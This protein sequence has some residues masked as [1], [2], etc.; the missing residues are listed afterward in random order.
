[1]HDPDFEVK[2]LIRV[3]DKAED[4]TVQVTVSDEVYSYL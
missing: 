2:R 4:E 3:Y 1:M